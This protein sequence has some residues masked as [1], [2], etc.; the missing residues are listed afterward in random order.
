MC[1]VKGNFQLDSHNYCMYNTWPTAYS[2]GRKWGYAVCVNTVFEVTTQFLVVQLCWIY[3]V[4][5]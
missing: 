2:S 4:D 5:Q 1:K 3:P